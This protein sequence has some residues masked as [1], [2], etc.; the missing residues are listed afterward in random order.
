VDLEV[1]PF[2][3]EVAQAFGNGYREVVE[4]ALAAHGDAHLRL[5][6]LALGRGRQR[7]TQGDE[8]DERA[9]GERK[10]ATGFHGVLQR[11]FR[12]VGM[13]VS[14]LCRPALAR[15]AMMLT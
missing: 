5:L 15:S 1:E 2:F 8:S 7:Q 9:C 3:L 11:G 4:L 6:D 13:I 14:G 12:R 10:A